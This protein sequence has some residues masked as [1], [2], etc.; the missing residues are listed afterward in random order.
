[1]VS[2][3]APLISAGIFSATLS[4]ALASLVSAPKIF[5]ALCKD[6]IY[7]GFSMFAKGY[8]KNNEPLRGYLLT[9]LIGLGFIL[10]AELNLIAP[11]ISNF[12]LASYALIN[13]SVFHAS[14]AKSPG[15]RPAFKYYNMWVSLVGAILCCIVMFVINWWAALLTYV[16]VLGL[17]I[18]VTYKKPDVNWGSSTQALTYLNALQHAVRL[19]GVEDHV[20]NFSLFGAVAIK[21][22][23]RRQPSLSEVAALEFLQ[24]A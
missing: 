13:F 3:F 1:M 24:P 20:K 4:S 10:I 21:G 6:N 2:G 5:Q 11:I 9:F 16:I 22:S 17:Y 15:W 8:G 12:F 19:T 23:R 18:Y 7:P 14:L